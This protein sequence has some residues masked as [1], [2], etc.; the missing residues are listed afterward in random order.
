M[1]PKKPPPSGNTSNNPLKNVQH[2]FG[3]RS[4]QSTHSPNRNAKGIPIIGALRF[5][6]GS[7][8]RKSLVSVPSGRDDH[9][10]HPQAPSM[11]EVRPCRVSAPS[12]RDDHHTHP[13]APSMSSHAKT[14]KQTNM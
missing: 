11:E 7:L 5:P 9:H 8:F 4:Q 2:G 12:G 10:T 3:N 6:L 1:P 13:Q 14:N